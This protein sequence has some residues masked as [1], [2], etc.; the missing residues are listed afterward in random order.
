MTR[1]FSEVCLASGEDGT[2]QPL[3]KKTVEPVLSDE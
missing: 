2:L 1:F 3:S